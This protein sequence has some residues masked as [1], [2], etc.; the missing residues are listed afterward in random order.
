[1]WTGNADT[2]INMHSIAWGRFHRYD[3]RDK[4]LWWLRDQLRGG[5]GNA[6]HQQTT[7]FI[8]MIT[9]IEIHRVYGQTGKHSKS[10]QHNTPDSKILY[11][12][13]S[14]TLFASDIRVQTKVSIR[15]TTISI[16]GIVM[17]GQ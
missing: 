6:A 5:K 8:Y 4:A 13:L 3:M 11:F 17:I 12:G 14:V 10:C 2:A 16:R 15:T 7:N 1:M 9:C